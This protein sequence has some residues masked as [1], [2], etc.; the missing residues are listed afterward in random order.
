MQCL[1]LIASSWISSAQ[2]GHFFI[3]FETS[4]IQP[5]KITKN[6]MGAHRLSTSP[7]DTADDPRI[8]ASFQKRGQSV[9]IHAN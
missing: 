3:G 7:Y 9:K 2:Y 1:H 4:V 8:V 6:S 5:I